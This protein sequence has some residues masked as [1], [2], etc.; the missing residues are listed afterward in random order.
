MND[1][2]P[3]PKYR[4]FWVHADLD[5]LVEEGVINTTEMYLACI[6]DTYV[7]AKGEGCWASNEHLAKRIG[8]KSP[9]HVAEMIAKLKALGLVKQVGWKVTPTGRFRILETKWSRLDGPGGIGKNPESG[10]PPSSGPPEEGGL[11]KSLNTPLRK[12]PDTP[13][14]KSPKY[15]DTRG[16]I[17]EIH[18]RPQAAE[19]VCK[20]KTAKG[21]GA[22]TPLDV[23]FANRLYARVKTLGKVPRRLHP[24]KWAPEFA[25]LRDDFP[26]A[27]RIK[28][29]FEWYLSHIGAKYVPEAYSG[30]AFRRK[31][32][33]IEAAMRKDLGLADD[34]EQAP[35]AYNEW[36]DGE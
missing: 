28:R 32:V 5:A 24:S 16:E 18:S 35:A 23:E 11:R 33:G 1:D 36:E 14:R 15:R 30:S 3:C 12:S 2:T 27:K 8:L 21:K 31:F 25:K 7:S 13:L 4:G 26:D 6:I 9:T 22:H 34:D 17:Q 19:R 20:P 10:I 29:V